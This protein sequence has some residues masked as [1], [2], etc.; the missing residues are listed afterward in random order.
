[1]NSM[2][3]VAIA[4]IAAL[5][6][7]LSGAVAFAQAQKSVEESFLQESLETMVIREQAQA[8]NKDMKLVALQYV[9]QA[10]DAG[11]KNEEIRKS[12]E[13]LALENTNVIIRA[14]GSGRILNDYPDIRAKA[15]DYLGEF[16]SV[17]TKDT[18]V[19]V[20]LGDR[21]PMVL[22]SAIRSLGR[23]GINEADEV[24]QVIAFLISRFDVLYPDNSLAFEGLIA[25]ERIADKQGGLKDPAA[26][27][28]IMKIAAGNYITPV[29]QRA[30]D[31]LDR[32]RKLSLA[33][34]ASSGK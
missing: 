19:K 6:F 4:G 5:F 9:K 22:S 23:I 32:L 3:R 11:R 28:A 25:L 16:P 17:E 20:A 7:L 14:A 21:E 2:Y 30:N 27:R 1:M 15:C 8:E 18:L 12:L 10:I 26:I 33:G 13:Y 29:K 31:L 34:A 24:T